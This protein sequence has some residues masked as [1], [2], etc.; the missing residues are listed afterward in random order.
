M[1]CGQCRQDMAC[2]DWWAVRDGIKQAKD[3]CAKGGDW[4]RK[5][6]LKVYEALYAVSTRDFATAAR[7]FLDS[8]AT[9]TAC[10]CLGSPG[11]AVHAVGTPWGDCDPGLL[12][13][14]HCSPGACCWQGRA[15]AVG[16]GS[17]SA[18]FRV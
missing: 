7:L 10:A 18:S 6:R 13:R 1:T 8:I 12:Y 9:F 15:A 2:G 17:G 14:V 4:E 16:T 11:A 5:N 3:L